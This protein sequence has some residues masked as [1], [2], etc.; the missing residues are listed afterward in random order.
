MKV[1]WMN[2]RG[3]DQEELQAIVH[4]HGEKVK[5]IGSAPCFALDESGKDMPGFSATVADYT[6][7]HPKGFI[8]M[9][10]NEYLR[11]DANLLEILATYFGGLGVFYYKHQRREEPIGGEK[12]KRVFTRRILSHVCHYDIGGNEKRVWVNQNNMQPRNLFDFLDFSNP[13]PFSKSPL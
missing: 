5:I 10:E 13:Q 9:D 6:A 2:Y 1:L 7:K 12:K 4:L 11:L 8:Y 3:M